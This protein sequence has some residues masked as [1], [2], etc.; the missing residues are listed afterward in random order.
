VAYAK[1]RLLVAAGLVLMTAACAS[2]KTSGAASS[3]ALPG[4]P[5]SAFTAGDAKTLLRASTVR[6]VSFKTMLN[7]ELTQSAETT[8][9]AG[10]SQI[11]AVNASTCSYRTGGASSPTASYQYDFAVP[12]FFPN[13]AAFL[14]ANMHTGSQ[15]VP[16][17]GQAAVYTQDAGSHGAG[18]VV[19][20]AGGNNF[21]VKAYNSQPSKSVMAA[22]AKTVIGRL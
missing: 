19:L 8:T 18:I 7:E 10:A 16:G 21:V 13:V 3:K 11:A 1:R 17:V 6:E 14:Q 12:S 2:D 15:Q 20:L 22:V 9:A 5:C 4:K